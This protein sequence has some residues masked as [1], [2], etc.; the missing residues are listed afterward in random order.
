MPLGR[1]KTKYARSKLIHVRVSER[2][3]RALE[4]VHFNLSH[5]IR[6]C[7]RKALGI[8]EVKENNYQKK[9]L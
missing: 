5:A 2:E 4:K 6:T 9:I 8:R 3:L 7:I 1:V